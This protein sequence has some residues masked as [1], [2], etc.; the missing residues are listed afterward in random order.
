LSG[1]TVVQRGKQSA[2]VD[3][4]TKEKRQKWSSG[5]C[6]RNEAEQF[7]LNLAHYPGFN[8][9]EGPPGS[10]CLNRLDAKPTP[11]PPGMID[12]REESPAVPKVSV[13]I[14]AY[15]VAPYISQC[16]ASVFAQTHRDYE[17]IVIDDGSTDATAEIVARSSEQVRLLRQRNQGAAAARNAGI[18]AARGELIAFLDADDAWLPDYLARQVGFWE[19]QGHGGLVMCNGYLWD[20]TE[21]ALDGRDLLNPTV[22]NITP[23]DLLRTLLWGNPGIWTPAVLIPRRVLLDLGGFNEGFPVGEDTRLWV[24]LALRGVR[25]NYQPIP[26]FLRRKR[27]SSLS[28]DQDRNYAAWVRILM[29]VYDHPLVPEGVKSQLPRLLRM[30]I[31]DRIRR[32]KVHGSRLAFRTILARFPDTRMRLMVT[33]ALLA[34]R[35]LLWT[36]FGLH[37]LRRFFGHELGGSMRINMRRFAQ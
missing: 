6:T 15:N 3:P 13:V 23:S 22:P 19:A 5:L 29:E 24:E 10:P 17:V 31:A 14:P 33:G 30:Q 34:S 18:L 21:R 28:T 35:P 36:L 25:F 1:T 2:V 16:L 4:A 32:G 7:R 8:A 27:A 12:S 20:E 37:Q 26:L 9:G 11:T